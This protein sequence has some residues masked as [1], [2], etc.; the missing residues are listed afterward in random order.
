MS[1]AAV[2]KPKHVIL[3]DMTRQRSHLFFRYLSTHPDVE[4]MWH[5]ILAPFSYGPERLQIETLDI[6]EGDVP[7]EGST[8][9]DAIDSIYKVK[10]HANGQVR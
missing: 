5:P 8:Y 2:A 4:A 9:Q 3:Y 1:P 7:P 6:N 10:E